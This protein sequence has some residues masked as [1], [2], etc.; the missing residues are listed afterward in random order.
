MANGQGHPRQK[1]PKFPDVGQTLKAKAL[2]CPSGSALPG[3]ESHMLPLSPQMGGSKTL[4]RCFTN[5]T[6]IPSIK[7]CYKVSLRKTFRQSTYIASD[8]PIGWLKMQTTCMLCHLMDQLL[9][10]H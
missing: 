8:V 9:A 6:D 7:L 5:K 2:P 3:D 4:L 1:I 10:L